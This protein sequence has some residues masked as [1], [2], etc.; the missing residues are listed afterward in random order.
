MN[1]LFWIFF[2]ACLITLLLGMTKPELFKKKDGTITT[3]KQIATPT[4]IFLVIFFVL[5][6]STSKST[7]Q[8]PSQ[9]TTSE[10]QKPKAVALA[11]TQAPTVTPKPTLTS[12]QIIANFE[13]EA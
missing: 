13:K 7:D 1:I 8:T 12:Q 6:I 4:L 2:F 9:N 5:A 10:T 3:R 11:A